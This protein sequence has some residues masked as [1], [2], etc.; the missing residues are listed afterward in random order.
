MDQQNTENA[1]YIC[2]KQNIVSLN[3][4][5]FHDY[6]VAQVTDSKILL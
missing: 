1:A 6:T 3:V 4:E 5:S 2:S